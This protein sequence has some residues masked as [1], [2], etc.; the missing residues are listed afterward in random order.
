[1]SLSAFFSMGGHGA[2]VWGAYGV[3]ALLLA[4]EV[5]LLRRDKAV[6]QGDS[7]QAQ[8]A[9]SGMQLHGQRGS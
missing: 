9:A 1:M 3:T 2:F 8:E 6:S 7:S 4:L 5:M